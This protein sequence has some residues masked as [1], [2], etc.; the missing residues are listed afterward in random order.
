[1]KIRQAEKTDIAKL[2]AL[3]KL[4]YAKAFGHT[5]SASDLASHLA[6]NLSSCSFAEVLTKDVVLLAKRDDRLVGF[7]Q[8]GAAANADFATETAT[9]NDQELR[10]L[11]VH[12]D[13]QNQGVG[14]RLMEAALEHPSLKGAERI[15]LDVWEYN[16]GAQRFYQRYGFKVIGERRFYVESGAETS[17]DLIM[18]RY[19]QSG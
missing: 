8:F 5:F 16:Y 15:F 9:S 10:R 18:V 6:K 12:A 4:T 11:Y 19:C 14:T 13:F 3:A 7:V 1:M 2:S 17:L